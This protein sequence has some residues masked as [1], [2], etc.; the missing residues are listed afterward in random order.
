MKP[1]KPY[2]DMTA[3]EFRRATRES[4]YPFTFEVGKPL[5]AADRAIF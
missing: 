1:R 4:D 3:A 5:T 2:S